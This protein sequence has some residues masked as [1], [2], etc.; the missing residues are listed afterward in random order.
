MIRQLETVWVNNK[1]LRADKI[2][3]CVLFHREYSSVVCHT[4]NRKRV[5]ES[6]DKGIGNI[7]NISYLV[8]FSVCVSKIK[9]MATLGV[10][11]YAVIVLT[12]LISTGIGIYY[13]QTG[14]K[15]KST[16][17]G[18]NVFLFSLSSIRYSK[19]K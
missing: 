6:N 10:A 11:D 16:E 12:M 7:I 8:K 13:W 1:R 19:R 15:E 18:V 17:V 3:S 2:H 5:K 9:N 14:R 4:R